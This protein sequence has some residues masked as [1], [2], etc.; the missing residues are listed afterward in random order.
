MTTNELREAAQR[1][2]KLLAAYHLDPIGPYRIDLEA[3]RD[4]L[5]TLTATTN[6][7]AAQ[8]DGW[9]SV[10]D[11]MPEP[12]TECI[13]WIVRNPFAK[14]PYAFIDTWDVT[15]EDPLGMGG[16]TIETGLGWGD[17]EFEDISHWMPMPGAPG[18]ALSAQPVQAR[19]EA[20]AWARQTTIDDDNGR[21]IGIDEPEVRWGAE[22]PD[23]AE[24]WSPLYAHPAPAVDRGLSEVVREALVDAKSVCAS[25][26]TDRY[27]KLVLSGSVMY[28]QTEEWCRWAYDE[29]LPKIKAAL[30]ASA[31]SQAEPTHRH[32]KRGTTY[33]E[34]ARGRLQ[35]DEGMILRDMCPLV[36]YQS[37]D[38]GEW[39]FRPVADFDN[40]RR[41]EKVAPS[42]AGSCQASGE[43]LRDK[44]QKQCSD[45]SVYWRGSDA[46]GV[47]LSNGQALV[48]LRDALGV[49]VEI[50][51]PHCDDTGDVHR[52]D[53]E[54]LGRCTCL[55]GA[56]PPAGRTLT[57]EEE[58]VL[59]R[60]RN[61]ISWLRDGKN[62]GNGVGVGDFIT[63]ER[64][65]AASSTTAR[66]R[67]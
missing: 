36:A 48:L 63:L 34:R 52:A 10:H 4:A 66:E 44:L 60:L 17:N 1:I 65:L 3:I 16:P 41:F 46:H 40:P 20:V 37:T 14:E 38:D 39:W 2:D 62:I 21:P 25:V 19:G 31:P 61:A 27:R 8:A 22:C 7:A 9:I 29:V 42:Q 51:C 26:S 58:G 6:E 33:T 12:G 49:E 53:G 47:K 11:R 13:V 18:A 30:A 15:R 28:A 45:W 57:A 50:R 24:D 43:A 54:W 5:A 59:Q 64:W 67:G 35:V 55:A 23:P 32:I 56:A